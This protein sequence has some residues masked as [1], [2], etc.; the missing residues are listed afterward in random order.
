MKPQGGGRKR[1]KRVLD[2]LAEM[3]SQAAQSKDPGA[4]AAGVGAA[5]L[6]LRHDGRPPRKRKDGGPRG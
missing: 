4:W 3:V 1:R 5:A 2:G 6:V